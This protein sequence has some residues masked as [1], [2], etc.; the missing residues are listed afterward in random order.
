[1]D[2]LNPYITRYSDQPEG[3]IRNYDPP[4]YIKAG[5]AAGDF[6]GFPRSE[7]P[8]RDFKTFVA[9][10][11]LLTGGKLGNESL[12][13]LIRVLSVNASEKVL[14]QNSPKAAE[15]MYHTI[16]TMGGL[17]EPSYN[18]SA[19]Q[20]WLRKL[21]NQKLSRQNISG[22]QWGMPPVALQGPNAP[23][24]PA[25]MPTLFPSVRGNP[26]NARDVRIMDKILEGQGEYSSPSSIHIGQ[27]LPRVDP[28]VDP[29]MWETAINSLNPY[30][31]YVE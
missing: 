20:S 5:E 24:A 13:T 27:Y 25:R 8:Q 10:L 7:D 6:L 11:S 2:E 15:S 23:G 29:E 1:M 4:W 17:F 21:H 31:R 19:T 28:P 26:G 14:M 18:E 3:E 22:L 9:V 30:L 16:Q 12:D